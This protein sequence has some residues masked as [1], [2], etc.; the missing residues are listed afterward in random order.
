MTGLMAG[1]PKGGRNMNQRHMA[2]VP[3]WIWEY[4]LKEAGRENIRASALLNQMIALGLEAR[5]AE[6]LENE[7]AKRIVDT[8]RAVV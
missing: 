6:K 2:S 3:E 8:I 1:L 5:E 7:K 4:C